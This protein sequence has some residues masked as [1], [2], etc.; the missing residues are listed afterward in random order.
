LVVVT[1]LGDLVSSLLFGWLWAGMG[2][3]VA[4]LVALLPIL[5]GMGLVLHPPT[6]PGAQEAVQSNDLN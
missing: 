1:G 2:V 3:H 4:A 6:R 5:A